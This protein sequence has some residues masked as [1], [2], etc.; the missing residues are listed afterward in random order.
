MSYSFEKTKKCKCCGKIFART[1]RRHDFCSIVCG[2]KFRQR[3]YYHNNKEKIAERRRLWRIENK[4]KARL[5]D[6]K[7][8]DKNKDKRNKARRDWYKKN[9]RLVKQKSAEWGAKNKEKKKE[10]YNKWYR[11]NKTKLNEKR[12]TINLKNPE[13]IQARRIASRIVMPKN[14]ICQECNNDLAV[15]KHHNDYF[16]PR[17]ILFVCL[18][19]HNKLHGKEVWA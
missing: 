9:K 13:K 3:Q 4:E 1:G 2:H 7:H 15:H 16:K 5:M 12:R 17:E 11:K 14:Q 10:N 19:C 6:K 8:R 18:S